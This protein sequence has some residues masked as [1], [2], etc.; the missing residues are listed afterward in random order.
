MTCLCFTADVPTCLLDLIQPLHRLR[1][2]AFK[3]QAAGWVQKDG[4]SMAECKISD[5]S[6]K[7]GLLAVDWFRWFANKIKVQ[8]DG[9]KISDG[10]VWQ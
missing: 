1:S 2:K 10:F 4:F 9:S 8:K 5:G 7:L 6:R 3:P